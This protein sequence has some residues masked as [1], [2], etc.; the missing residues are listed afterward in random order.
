MKAPQADDFGKVLQIPLLVKA[1][2]TNSEL[3]AKTSNLTPR[4]VLYYAEAAEM[5]GFIGKKDR[6][7]FLTK[8]GENFANTEEKKIV[9]FEALKRVP[10]IALTLQ[11]ACKNPEG[12]I[13][14]G[15]IADLI[16]SQTGLSDATAARRANSVFNWL[17]WASYH[18][19]QFSHCEGEKVGVYCQ[20]GQIPGR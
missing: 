1:G 11:E 10:V 19:P 15:H 5:L 13:T 12:K 18:F 9:A 8:E 16:K 17:Y 6:K 4:Q 20:Y 2:S 3:L 7:Y 14:K